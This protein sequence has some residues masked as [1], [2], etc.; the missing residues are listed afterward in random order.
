HWKAVCKMPISQ[1]GC[2]S[3]DT[4]S[5]LPAN[6]TGENSDPL[7]IFQVDEQRYG[8]PLSVVERIVA[9]VEITL[10]PKQVESVL[11]VVNL[12]G[13]IVPVINLRKRFGLPEREIQLSDQLIILCIQGRNVALVVDTITG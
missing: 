13:R 8:L 2:N 12:Q 7:A 9:M 4:R 3:M 1:E 10:L 6:P 5:Q 11:G